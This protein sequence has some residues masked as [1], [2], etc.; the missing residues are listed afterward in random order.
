[1]TDTTVR[2]Y[3]FVRTK[4]DGTEVQYTY[5]MNKYR[6]RKGYRTVPNEK[7]ERIRALRAEGKSIPFIIKELH[8][9]HATIYRALAAADNPPA[10]PAAA[11]NPPTD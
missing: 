9:S 6:P 7:L 10:E 3:T 5:D 2:L 1:M 11:D 4:V 8:T